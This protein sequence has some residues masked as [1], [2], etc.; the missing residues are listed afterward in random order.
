MPDPQN[1]PED[2]YPFLYSRW[3]NSPYHE[4][5]HWAVFVLVS[6]FF[7]TTIFNSQVDYYYDAHDVVINVG[8]VEAQSTPAVISTPNDNIPDF[9]NSP[10]ITSTGSGNWS[11]PAIWNLGRVP[12]NNDKV[13]IAQ[14]STVTYSKLCWNQRNSYFQAG[15][16]YQDT[17][18]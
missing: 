3:H 11:D 2:I 7:A 12:T 1:S 9:C 18:R 6:I 5:F 10:T 8:R 14:N 13:S 16:Q 17:S 4:P 15:Y